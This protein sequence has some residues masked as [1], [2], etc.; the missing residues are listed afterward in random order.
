MKRLTA[1][2]R[3]TRIPDSVIGEMSVLAMQ[4]RAINLSSGYP[5]FDPPGELLAAAAAALQAG[6]NQYGPSRGQNALRQA[7]AAKHSRFSGLPVDPE[8][9]VTV[10][11]GSTEAMLAIMLAL[12]DPGDRVIVFSP[13][14]ENYAVDA[15]LAG[16][17]PV[18]FSLR[19]PDFQVDLAALRRL[20]EQGAKALVFCN[21]S[22]PTGK[23]FSRTELAGIAE[24]AQEFDVAVIVD[25]VYEHIVFSPYRHTH[26]ASLPG[27][28]ERTI[29]CG[30]LSKTYSITGWRLGYVIAP[31]PISQGVKT[32]HEYISLN[33]ATPLQE[34]A[35][36]ALNF[37]DSYYTDLSLAYK[38]RCEVLLQGLA[39]AGLP[40]IE[41]QGGY[42]VLA[43]ISAFGF[44]DDTD[45]CRWLIR[46]IGVAAVPGSSF[47]AEPLHHLIR[48]TFSKSEATLLEGAQRLKRIRKILTG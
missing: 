2:Q 26:L 32:L 24:L 25:E 3:L 4:H 46:E 17:E 44:E 20:L 5:D 8:T 19:P 14:Y 11:C 30:S 38:R 27:M 42:F 41:P 9:H 47:F 43:D 31:E 48:L 39:E 36:T 29:T 7:L 18:Y 34:A 16:A 28:F 33:A 13:F 10:T 6:Y 45:F 22:N 12:C 15:L 35:V 1:S 23:V 21:P 37:P 40:Y